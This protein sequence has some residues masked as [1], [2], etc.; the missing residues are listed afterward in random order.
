MST[1]STAALVKSPGAVPDGPAEAGPSGRGPRSRSTAA[2]LRY[3]AGK[4]A[5]AAVSLFAVLVTSFFLFRMIP[6]DPVKHMT[7]GRPV[8]TEQLAAMR[9][10]F[11]LDLPMWQQFTDYCGKALTGDFGMSYQFRAPVI[12]KV[13]EA[14]P[15]TLLL[16]GTAFVLY[17]VLGIW[18]GARSAW[19]SGKFGD[20]FST[21]F[22]LTLYS[23][24]SFWLGLLLI[25]TLSVGVGPIPGMFPTGGMES[26][27][28]SG[29]GYVLDVAH[30][31]VLPVLTLV[32]VEYA[33]TLLVMRSSLLDEMGSDYLTT[34]RAKGLRDDAVRRRHAVPNALLPTVTL[35]FVNLGNTVAGAILVETVF[36]WPGLGGL[37]YQALSVPDLP[38][39]QGLF[40]LFAAAVIL[41][42]TLA[43]VIYPLLDPRVGR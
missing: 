12:D 24:P 38:L 13:A 32:A 18:L 23:V 22:A 8:S 39:V 1:D 26:G 28:Q 34:A 14:L 33:R 40:F 19:R 35:L 25:I 30:H 36:S 4:L 29:F 17:T 9:R 27:G 21:A 16:T 6:G 7:Q 20:R 5:G 41:M 3:V 2:Y 42:N 15:A 43:D 31:M 37:F 11:G 10:E